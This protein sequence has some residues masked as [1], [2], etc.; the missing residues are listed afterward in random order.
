MN[1]SKEYIMPNFE[2]KK[3]N[4]KGVSAIEFALIAPIL[5]AMLFGAVEATQAI[6]VDRKVTQASSTL[7]DIVTQSATLDC[8]GLK[9]AFAATREVISPYSATNASLHIASVAIVDA[10]PKV[11]W[12]RMVDNAGVCTSSTLYPVGTLVNIPG[13]DA[14]GNAINLV[15]GM[16]STGGSIIIGDVTLPYTSIGTSFFPSSVNLQE[17]YFLKPRI[18]DKVCYSGI[19]TPGC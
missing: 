5:I 12:S 3:L 1:L 18:S 15:T 11:E 4:N 9:E 16:I 8:N 17:R 14:G 6:S 7:A 13:T 19:T 10:V 2:I